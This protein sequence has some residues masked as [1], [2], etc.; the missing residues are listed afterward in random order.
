MTG[1]E[2]AMR[3][4]LI[5]RFA[6]VAVGLILI[7]AACSK[8]TP[9][10]TNQSSNTNTTVN[11]SAREPA[12]PAGTIVVEASDGVLS[13]AEPSTMDF[14]AE[15]AA[16]W[17]A[18]LGSKG[19]T[20]TFPVPSDTTGTFTLWVKTSDDGTWNSGYRDANVTVNGVQVLTYLH[21]S[22][23]TNGW[24]WQKLGNVSLKNGSNSVAFTKAN[25]MPAA[26]SMQALKL[27]PV[28]GTQ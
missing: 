25:D 15:I 9:V 26:Y 6:M 14:V 27:I 28:P 12:D 10:V 4:N 23:N 1:K 22:Q 17:V 20:V 2:P 5:I 24:K 21:V 8:K 16:G 7:G 3:N 18:Y 11:A 19:A 13:G